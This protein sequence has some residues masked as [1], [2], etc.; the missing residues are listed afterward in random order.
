MC[1]SITV[2]NL[3]SY[4]SLSFAPVLG[5]VF[6]PK[7]KNRKSVSNLRKLSTN[8]LVH[9][10]KYALTHHVAAMNGDV[11]T[12]IYKGDVIPTSAGGAQ[13]MFNDIEML[14]QISPSKKKYVFPL[15]DCSRN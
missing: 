2:Y 6:T 4:P 1:A 5:T 11:E 12:H 13:I 10:S 15:F 7:I 3:C 14:Q 8:D 9:A